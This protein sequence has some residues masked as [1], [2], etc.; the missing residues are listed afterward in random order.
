[1]TSKRKIETT[2]ILFGINKNNEVE[3]IKTAKQV[4]DL[5]AIIEGVDAEAY[6]EVA[7]S[8]GSKLIRPPQKTK[9][10]DNPKPELKK[11]EIETP[12]KKKSLNSV[13][14]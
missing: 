14:S 10:A 2:A 11:E 12:K 5:L 1:M 6:S 9:K 13:I 7:I 3:I 8:R 4:S